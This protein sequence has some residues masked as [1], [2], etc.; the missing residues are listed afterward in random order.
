[1]SRHEFDELDKMDIDKIDNIELSW[2][3]DKTRCK[4]KSMIRDESMNEFQKI[5]MQEPVMIGL[6]DE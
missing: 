6:F 4:S 2:L 1:M 3:T 5:P